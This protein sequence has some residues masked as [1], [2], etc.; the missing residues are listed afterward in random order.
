MA[1]F[2]Y[3]RQS[4]VVVSNTHKSPFFATNQFLH[5]RKYIDNTSCSFFADQEETIYPLLWECKHTKALIQEI[6]KW[7]SYNNKFISVSEISLIFWLYGEGTSIS[8]QKILL[9]RKYY[10]YFCK[11]SNASLNIMTLKRRLKLIY[12]TS[13]KAAISLKTFKNGLNIKNF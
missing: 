13:K 11:C 10:I 9:E 8:E 6:R 5:T 2:H 7:L 1:K 4:I 3:K 12:D